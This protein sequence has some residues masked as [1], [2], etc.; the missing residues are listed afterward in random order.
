M[1][2]PQTPDVSGGLLGQ[3]AD[4]EG[5]G[6]GPGSGSG[7]GGGEGNSD[8]L[9]QLAQ[10]TPFSTDAEIKIDRL[11]RYRTPLLERLFTS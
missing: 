9:T 4:P 3:I 6:I 1:L 11:T 7:S 10:E 5:T 8:L 2:D